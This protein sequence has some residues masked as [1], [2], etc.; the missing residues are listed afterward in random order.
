MW[1]NDQVNGLQLM[2]PI[3]EQS[4]PD[5]SSSMMPS[6]LSSPTSKAY[7]SIAI[8]AADATAVAPNRPA[9]AIASAASVRVIVMP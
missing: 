5:S 6:P 4:Q 9:N 7:V 1:L 8:G 2:L 3:V